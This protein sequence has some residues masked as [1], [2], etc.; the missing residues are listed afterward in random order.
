MENIL[1]ED[2][3][4]NF[5]KFDLLTESEQISYMDTWTPQQ[6]MQYLMRNTISE[7][8]CFTPI[9]KLIDETEQAMNNGSSILCNCKDSII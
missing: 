9:F 7:E 1:K 5:H 4:I 2:G 6:R 8:E 3:S